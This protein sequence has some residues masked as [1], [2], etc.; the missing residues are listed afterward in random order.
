MD[1]RIKPKILEGEIRVIAS[2]S[3]IHRLL[4]ASALCDSP[5][6]ILIKD[7]NED[8]E[9]T[10][11][12]LDN[13]KAGIFEFPCGESG[14]TLRFLLPVVMALGDNAAFYG[15]GR[16]PE[17]PLSPLKEEMEKQGCVFTKPEKFSVLQENSAYGQVIQKV[18]GKLQPGVYNLSG[19]VSSQY[20]T[21]LLF[22]LPLLEGDSTINITT[23]LESKGYV[24]LTLSVL[25]AFGIKIDEVEGNFYVTG[26]QKYTPQQREI[27]PEAD[28]SN[29]AFWVCAD[30][31]SRKNGGSGVSCEGLNAESLQGDKAIVEIAEKIENN[32]DNEKTLVFDVSQIP[33][34]VP[35][36]SVLAAC[37]KRGITKI[38]N[39][40]RL[41]IKESDRLSAV[42]DLI[43]G[44]GGRA[45]EFQD[46][47]TIFGRGGFTGGTVS[48]CGDHRIV[49]AAAIAATGAREPVVIL[50]A[51]ACR[52]SYPAFFEDYVT[53]GGQIYGS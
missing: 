8:I 23:P 5:C 43:T 11:S 2:K 26:R 39:A 51:E 28:W 53:L 13:L 22:A 29:A 33:D 49:M 52:K 20:I 19:N 15:K 25:K 40:G 24:D 4:I 38:V 9:A 48:G 7:T 14:S 31:I 35:V 27:L 16:L 44:L 42:F 21:G 12:C 32:Y 47:L 37:R 10:L 45:E 3:H 46:A 50:G 30:V 41:R 17:R 6:S 34:L 36:I 18:K 1:I